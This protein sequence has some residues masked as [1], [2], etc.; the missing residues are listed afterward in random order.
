V[1]VVRGR[2]GDVA[3][4]RARSEAML[5]AV[6]RTGE[7]A[8]RVWRPHRQVAFGRRDAREAGFEAAADAARQ[9]GYEPVERSVGG[10]AVAYTGTTVAFARAT[11]LDDVRTGMDARYEAATA[12]VAAAL[13]DLGVDAER[14]EPDDAFCPGQHSLRTPEGGKLVGLAQRVRSGAA[15]VAGVAV[16]TDRA[17]LAGVLD[18]VYG[19]LGLSFD[20]E[21]VGS[22][23]A[24]GG[25]GDPGAVVGAVEDRLVGGRPAT[26]ERVDA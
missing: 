3:A 19:A 18:A 2:A 10:R 11:P 14:G 16:P 17:E 24:A 5:D 22:V 9:R 12:D 1:R 20:P 13:A 25:N 15:V 7:P 26:V 21:G 8:V 23:A 4:D 6:A